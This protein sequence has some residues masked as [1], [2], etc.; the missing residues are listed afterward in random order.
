MIDPNLFDFTHDGPIDEAY[1][2]L[3]LVDRYVNP[4]LGWARREVARRQML[5]EQ[6]MAEGLTPSE[7]IAQEKEIRLSGEVD[8]LVPDVEQLYGE[9]EGAVA[10]LLPSWFPEMEWLEGLFG[11]LLRPTYDPDKACLA[12]APLMRD[13]LDLALGKFSGLIDA[14]LGQVGQTVQDL[15]LPAATT[16]NALEGFVRSVLDD[17]ITAALNL[18]LGQRDRIDC[19]ATGKLAVGSDTIEAQIQRVLKT[20]TEALL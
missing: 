17:P 6:A 4:P 14:T 18:V 15:L 10:S 13:L 9:L 8:D 16:E 12:P 1:Q 5:I 11:Q 7:A 20:V 19:V 2:L 3:L